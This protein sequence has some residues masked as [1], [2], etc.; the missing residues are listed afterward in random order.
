MTLLLDVD[1]TVG[2]QRRQTSGGE[3]NRLDAYELDFHKR[4]REGY[5]QLAS[6]EPQR[7][8]LINAGQAPEMVQSDIRK[9]I[10]AKIP[11]ASQQD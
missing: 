8:H 1:A 4:L 9:V 7:W 2:L 11:L 5:L 3:W 6:E 10:E